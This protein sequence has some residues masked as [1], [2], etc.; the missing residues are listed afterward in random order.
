MATPEE[1]LL[2]EIDAVVT[3]LRKSIQT[4]EIHDCMGNLLSTHALTEKQMS[5]VAR[6]FSIN[7]PYYDLRGDDSIRFKD[8][9]G[10]TIFEDKGWHLDPA[11]PL[12]FPDRCAI[13]Y[14]PEYSPQ[15]T[16]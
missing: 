10:V 2:K 4:V 8:A 12:R 16:E 14:A 1:A 9:G 6:G 3:H 5:L 13:A 15:P 7:I 11:L